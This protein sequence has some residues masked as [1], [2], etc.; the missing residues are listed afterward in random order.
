MGLVSFSNTARLHGRR[1]LVAA[2]VGTVKEQRDKPNKVQ[3]LDSLLEQEIA[4][5][6]RLLPGFELVERPLNKYVSAEPTLVSPNRVSPDL[7]LRHDGHYIGLD[8]AARGPLSLR[9]VAVRRAAR[10]ERL[11]QQLPEGSLLVLVIQGTDVPLDQAGLSTSGEWE[12]VPA[13]SVDP[14]L[15][16]SANA[17]LRKPG[18][19]AVIFLGA[20]ILD[21]LLVVRHNRR[22]RYEKTSLAEAVQR[23]MALRQRSLELKQEAAERNRWMDSPATGPVKEYS[24]S[25][26]VLL[27]SPSPVSLQREKYLLV[28]D[29]LSPAKGGISSFNLE[30][31]KALRGHGHEVCIALPEEPPEAEQRRAKNHGI[32]LALPANQI[33]GVQGPPAFLTGIRYLDEGDFRPTVIVGHGRILGP[34]AYAIQK[35]HPSCSRL[36]LVHM[37]AEELERAKESHGGEP[38]TRTAADR[39]ELEV[40][41]ATSADVVA[42]VGHKLTGWIEDQVLA[43]PLFSARG[44]QVF[45]LLPGLRNFAPNRSRVPS[46]KRFLMTARADDFES[47]GI[48]TAIRAIG[49]AKRQRPNYPDTISLVIRGVPEEHTEVKRKVD[50]IALDYGYQPIFRPFSTNPDDIERD[51][52]TAVALLMPSKTEGFGLSA[53]EAIAAEVPVLITRDSGL[54]RLI[55]EVDGGSGWP[56]EALRPEDEQTWVDAVLRIL[57]HPES[58]FGRARRLRDEISQRDFWRASITK[59]E[60]AL[61]KSRSE[62]PPSRLTE[63]G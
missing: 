33:P 20:D 62:S 1:L 49:E 11:R 13:D 32:Q 7:V 26:D 22:I 30:F 60:T 19:D 51:L 40:E 36:H 25:G 57:D 15:R 58:S 50:E 45:C 12:T 35:Q 24:S 14:R 3:R 55:R 61:V 63:A 48:A 38:R 34:Y 23:P 42:G 56:T 29:E 53:Y 18:F 43:D 31:A 8:V 59:L 5:A 52:R 39:S 6:L 2:K 17:A 44:G 41:L 37:H 10:A 47:K 54:A 27:R 4:E 28:A 9:G 21:A 16:S 46:E